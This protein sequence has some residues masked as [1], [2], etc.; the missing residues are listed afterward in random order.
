METVVVAVGSVEA[1]SRCLMHR[2]FG[3]YKLPAQP[4]SP[5]LLHH[6]PAGS[7][8]LR[9]ERGFQT[10]CACIFLSGCAAVEERFRMPASSD[11][12]D[13]VVA[14][15]VGVSPGWPIG[16]PGFSVRWPRP[17]PANVSSECI[18]SAKNM[19]TVTK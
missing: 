11:S 5:W 9:G 18:S 14:W 17:P 1:G 13:T 15:V 7:T 4:V 10:G 2:S 3:D 19:L 6:A 12:C 8:L 16:W